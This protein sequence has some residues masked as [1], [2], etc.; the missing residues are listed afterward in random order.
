[1][2]T[3][4]PA[5]R[6]TSQAQPHETRR[7][8]RRRREHLRQFL[9][10]VFGCRDVNPRRPRRIRDAALAEFRSVAVSGPLL[11]GSCRRVPDAARSVSCCRG[12]IRRHDCYRGHAN[13]A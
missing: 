5:D 4:A 1:M 13:A 12:R 3:A 2:T 9:T 8:R 10:G 7:R 11:R 6:A